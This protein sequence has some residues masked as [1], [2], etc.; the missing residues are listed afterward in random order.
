MKFLDLLLLFVQVFIGVQSNQR[1]G[2][3]LSA[4]HQYQGWLERFMFDRR[5]PWI[6]RGV[7]FVNKGLPIMNRR[8][9]IDESDTGNDG[10]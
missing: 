9:L 7:P 1:A 4:Y 3:Q 6:N 8:F 2:P 5:L 10:G